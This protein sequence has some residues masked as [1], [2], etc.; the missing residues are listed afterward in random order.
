MSTFSVVAILVEKLSATFM[1]GA[2]FHF[3]LASLVN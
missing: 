2:R 1:L 3:V